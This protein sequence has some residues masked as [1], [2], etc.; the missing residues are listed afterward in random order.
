LGNNHFLFRESRQAVIPT[1]NQTTSVVKNLT[2]IA[3]KRL[4]VARRLF[5]MF[6]KDASGYL[7]ED[8]IPSIIQETYKEMGQNYQPSR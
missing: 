5:K 7:T 3:R 1:A 2:P 8:E 4:D 6:D